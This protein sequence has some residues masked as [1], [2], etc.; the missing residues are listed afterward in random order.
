MSKN[1]RD[2]SAPGSPCVRLHFLLFFIGVLILWL[3]VDDLLESVRLCAFRMSS[4]V[5]A[6]FSYGTEMLIVARES[7]LHGFWGDAWT[8]LS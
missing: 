6:L 2:P 4:C 8:R 7:S 1:C 5:I 3:G